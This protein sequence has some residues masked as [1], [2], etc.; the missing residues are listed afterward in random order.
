MNYDT[1][2]CGNRIRQLRL[3]SGLTQEKVA[4]ALNIDQSFYGRIELG[5]KGCSVD[6][7]IQISDL[8]GVSLDYLILG[9]NIGTLS[10]NADMA[11]IKAEIGNA[12]D[13]LERI[14]LSL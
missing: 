12:I 6:L 13:L 3:E 11:Q 8:F 14:K 2:T 1:K 7:F 4:S 5:K 10:K 9:R